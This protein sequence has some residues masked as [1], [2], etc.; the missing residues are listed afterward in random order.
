MD[1]IVLKNGIKI[2]DKIYEI[3][4]K[5]VILDRD[6]AKLYNIE[7]RV[8]IQSVKRNIK[9]FP[10]N[11]MFQ[12]TNEEFM[13]WRSHFVISKSDLIGL[14]RPPYAFT[15]EG[16]AMLSGILNSE[17]AITIN[18][19]IIEA[20][21]TI[22][23]YIS[24]GLIE[25]KYINNLVMQHEERL[26]LLEDTFSDFKEKNNHLFF[27]GQIYDAYT[28][29]IDIFNKSKKEI[30][31]IDNYVDKNILDILSKT[32][33][34]VKIYTNK[35]N[36]QDYEKYKMQYKN[37]DLIINNIFHDRFIIIDKTILYHCGA[38]FK[39]LG[40]QCFEISKIEDNDILD[41]L[42]KKL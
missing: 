41:D 24:S 39:D 42:L 21:I 7:T 16:V 28:L 15:E 17:I 2:E 35:Y 33:K 37:V 3:R 31:I 27:K 1:N 14:R 40:K 5:Q 36:N 6:L 38:S 18:I 13:N 20:F 26:K 12:L 10:D 30:I 4:G 11:F 23:K 34:N 9:R 8:F 32:N 25:Q 19:Q 22:R 29:L